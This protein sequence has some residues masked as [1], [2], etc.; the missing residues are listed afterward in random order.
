MRVT[1]PATSQLYGPALKTIFWGYKM[2]SLILALSLLLAGVTAS[3][4]GNLTIT[5]TDADGTHVLSLDDFGDH[6]GGTYTHNNETPLNVN[7]VA[8]PSAFVFSVGEANS[9]FN[10]VDNGSTSTYTGT[11]LDG[12]SGEITTTS[13]RRTTLYEGVVGTIEDLSGKMNPRKIVLNWEDNRLV[14]DNNGS[15][16][17]GGF[18]KWIRHGKTAQISCTST[19]TLAGTLFANPDH[20]IAIL[21]NLFVK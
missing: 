10:I 1:A 11:T 3:A 7:Y 16:S 8:D 18:V 5:S 6:L 12:K 9:I 17:C 19:G 14:I 13:K 4:Q 15:G 20:I 2:K 21:V